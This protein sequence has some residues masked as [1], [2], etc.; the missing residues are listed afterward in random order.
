MQPVDCAAVQEN[1]RSVVSVSIA[2]D[3]EEELHW[4]KCSK[5]DLRLEAPYPPQHHDV[6][7]EPVDG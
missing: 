5:C 1:T 6:E 4:Y 7:M 2:G 3:G